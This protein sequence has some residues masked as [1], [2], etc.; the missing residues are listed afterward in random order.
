MKYINEEKEPFEE[1]SVKKE[2]D[3]NKNGTVA[4]I[5]EKVCAKLV[6]GPKDKIHY[7]INTYQNQPFDPMGSSVSRQ[8]YLETKLK[9][10]S[11]DTFD[12]YL[13]YLQTKNSIYLTRTNRRFINE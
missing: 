10:V 8:N 4:S 5:K 9:R 11:K 1:L 6:L 13:I 3:F 12:F 7:F 2:T